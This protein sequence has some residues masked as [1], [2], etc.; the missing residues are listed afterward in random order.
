MRDWVLSAADVE[1]HDPKEAN[2]EPGDH[3][4]SEPFWALLR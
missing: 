4:W 1:D 2:D 3:E